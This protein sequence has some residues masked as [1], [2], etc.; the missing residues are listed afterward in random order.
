M[1]EQYYREA[2]AQNPKYPEALDNLARLTHETGRLDESEGLCAS[3]LAIQPRHADALFRLAAIQEEKGRHAASMST[4]RQLISIAPGH[5]QAFYALARLLLNG[6][7]GWREAG[8]R[9]ESVLAA[10]P[11]HV[12]A[13]CGLAS[14]L[15]REGRLEQ[16]EALCRRAIDLA[17]E[18]G[19][20]YNDLGSVFGSMARF[21]D[22]AEAFRKAIALA[23]DLAEA[24][25]NLGNVLV[26]GLGEYAEAEACI[27]RAIALKPQL[28]SA[29]VNLGVLLWETRREAEAE[30]SYRSALALNPAHSLARL[31]LG[32]L[33]LS[34]GRYEEA[35][36]LH[37]SRLDP[38]LERKLDRHNYR[39]HIPCW[40]GEPLA[41]KSVLVAAEQG[42]GDDIQFCRL[43]PVLVQRTGARIT[44]HA[45]PALVP[46]LKSL[47]DVEVEDIS[48]VPSGETFDYWVPLMSLPHRLGI[49]MATIPGALPYLTV[50][51][52]RLEKWRSRVPASGF[53]VGLVW[54]GNPKHRNDRNRS[55]ATLAEL[56]PLWRVP[57][58][59][60]VSLQMGAG[61][62][63]ARCPPDV[64]PLV[65]FGDELT[66]FGDT[67]AIVSL[68]DLV[69]C[70]DTAVAHLAGALARP[71]WVLVPEVGTD[72]RWLRG[73][74]DSPWYPGVMRLFRQHSRGGWQPTI[75]RVAEALQ[76]T[77]VAAGAAR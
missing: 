51:T 53:R 45:R 19:P 65:H 21:G 7:D 43:L 9:F 18:F 30:A 34:C 4:L 57:G 75:A 48:R 67:A 12:G 37:E 49:T 33:L 59:R 77:A 26:E 11:Q 8:V 44:F 16:A 39:T 47:P 17:P 23:P 29:H 55:L 74:D 54:Q 62:A 32:M 36:P 1:A 13:L 41:G 71:C 5:M 68:L 24:Y 35:W 66:D 61:A 10:D 3:I 22:A 64:Q 76:E 70:V 40:R 6:E 25:D 58:T 46:V 52:A 73:R 27:R 60:F 63:E 56:A 2:I 50:P 15:L 69:I 42:F 72:W 14:V 38:G 31:N 20:A 28:V